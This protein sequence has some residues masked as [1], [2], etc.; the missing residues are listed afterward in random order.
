MFYSFHMFNFLKVDFLSLKKLNIYFHKF[1]QTIFLTI[2]DIRTSLFFAEIYSYNIFV[3]LT[4]H[5]TLFITEAELD[6]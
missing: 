5:M 3:N 2:L 6:Q 4:A 1:K